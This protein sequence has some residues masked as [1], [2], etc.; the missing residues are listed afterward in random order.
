M[1]PRRRVRRR[2]QPWPS[3]IWGTGGKRE[4][5]EEGWGAADAMSAN[6]RSDL[7]TMYVTI[8]VDVDDE[9]KDG[10]SFRDDVDSVG[11]DRRREM[12]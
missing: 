4:M 8:S 2:F 6:S 10:T 5:A 7:Q 11:T 1:Q 9:N 3:L 12:R